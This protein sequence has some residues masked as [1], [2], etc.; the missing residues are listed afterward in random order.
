[1]DIHAYI[2]SGIIESY[3]LGIAGDEEK[4][5]LDRLRRIYPEVENAIHHAEEWLQGVS[6]PSST[7]VP[8]KVKEQIFATIHEELRKSARTAEIRTG[9]PLNRYLVAAS[10]ILLTSSVILNMVLYF[11]YRTEKKNV[12]ALQEEHKGLLVK[13]NLVQAKL[14]SFGDDLN[15]VTGSGSSRIVMDAVMGKGS[16]QSTLLMDNTGKQLLLVSNSLPTAPAGK[17]YQLWAIVNGKP[18]N[19]GLLSD[20]IP[21][22]KFPSVAHAQAYAVTLEPS[23]GSIGPTLDQMFVFGKVNS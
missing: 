6:T 20:C 17:Q 21:Y 2:Q 14:I 7:P 10:L 16:F 3:L 12:M 22:C 4:Q 5:E 18:V 13:N 19:A 8:A 23:G 1:M 11:K 9:R 15:R